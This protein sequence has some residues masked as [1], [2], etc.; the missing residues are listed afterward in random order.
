M[1][2]VPYQERYIISDF[3]N[4]YFTK[5]G[6]GYSKSGQE[7]GHR[8]KTEK[9]ICCSVK[10]KNGKSHKKRL[11]I[12]ILW[13]CSGEA[14][15]GRECDHIDGDAYN[16]SY[17]NLQWLDPTEHRRKTHRDN[18]QIGSLITKALN[19]QCILTHI[20]TGQEIHFNS[21]GEVCDFLKLSRKNT[22]IAT[23]IKNDIPLNGY[24]IKENDK[25]NK[26]NEIW[27]TIYIDN[28]K[29]IKVSN[30]GRIKS[31]NRILKCSISGGYNKAQFKINGKSKA[32][33]VHE[34][35]CRA[36]HSPKPE[37]ASSVNHINEDRLDNRPENLEWSTPILQASH[38]FSRKIILRNR[39]NGEEFSFNSMKDAGKFAGKSGGTISASIKRGYN[40]VGE[41]D[42]I[43]ICDKN[44]RTSRARGKHTNKI[45]HPNQVS[46][47][48]LKG[49]EK[50]EFS[51]ISDASKF[52]KITISTA[53]EAVNSTI[54]C[55]G[56]RIIK[57]D[58]YKPD[59][60]LEKTWE[61]KMEEEQL[62][63]IKNII[64][65]YE[66]EHRIPKTRQVNYNENYLGTYLQRL[67]QYDK[68]NKIRQSVKQLLDTKIPEWNYTYEQI[69]NNKVEE[70]I[71]FV[72]KNGYKPSCGKNKPKVEVLLGSFL[73]KL[74]M[75]YNNS[76]NGNYLNTKLYKSSQ[77]LLDRHFPDWKL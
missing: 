37:W 6:Y 57:K 62:N 63:I 16:N 38:S 56:W 74:K 22:K 28:N 52:L 11:H 39:N 19:Q 29:Q 10:D 46:V 13:A 3:P 12:L 24:K 44:K 15:N 21:K 75:S 23:A 1:T 73:N 59:M 65:F 53:C 47:I 33:G 60:I 4:Y 45:D 72:N 77:N 40:R 7:I 58:N 61:E 18:Q 49:D 69:Q 51:S 5:N 43:Y 76:G 9:Y 48:L 68:K 30:L 66:K 32:Y 2:T 70:L 31:M 64:D 26:N 14:P 41:Y 54:L 17:E 50:C 36:F 25:K 27:K 71:D 55:K 8:P 42:I 67:K 20:E 34:L 35:V